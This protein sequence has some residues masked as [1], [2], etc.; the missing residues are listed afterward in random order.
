MQEKGR[1]G[2]GGGGEKVSVSVESGIMIGGTSFCPFACNCGCIKNWSP[3]SSLHS[4]P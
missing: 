4:H 1:R 2:G 3:L